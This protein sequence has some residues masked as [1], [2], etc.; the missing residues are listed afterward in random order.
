MPNLCKILAVRQNLKRIA[1]NIILLKKTAKTILQN[2]V[3]MTVVHHV[4]PA[5]LL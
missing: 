1:V 4:L 2:L 3:M 5:L